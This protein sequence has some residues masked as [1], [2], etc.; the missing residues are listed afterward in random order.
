MK[1]LTD[2]QEKKKITQEKRKKRRGK[3]VK[4]KVKTDV[5]ILNPKNSAFCD[6]RASHVNI[7]ILHVDQ[8]TAKCT[9]CKLNS[10]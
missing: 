7:N 5:T 2:Q 6:A 9:T 4:E 10:F 8:K 1:L 3:K